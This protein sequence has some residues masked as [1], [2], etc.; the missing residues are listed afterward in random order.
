MIIKEI[1]KRRSIRSYKADSVSDEDIKE[2]IKSAQFAPTANDNRAVEFVIIKDP[3]IKNTIFSFVD[4]EYMNSAPVLIVPVIDK[5]KSVTPVEDL[6]IASEHIFLQATAL[7][8]GT[9]WKHLSPE[10]VEKIKTLL[11]IPE[12]FTM[13][14]LIPLGYAEEEMPEHSD[15]EFI[16]EKIH[17]EKW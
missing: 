7:G 1:K 11:D 2:I 15:E 13:I 4:Q 12:N 8:L 5:E 16:L 6:S 17:Q 14:N 9:V 3:E 10:W